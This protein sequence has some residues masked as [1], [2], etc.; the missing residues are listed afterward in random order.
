MTT[1]ELR[2]EIVDGVG[3]ITLNRPHRHNAVTDDLHDDL[4]R[5]TEAYIADAAVRCI[6]LRGEGPSFCSGR[7]TAELGR[8]ATDEDDFSFVLGHQRARLDVLEARKPVVAAI[9]GVALGGGFEIALAADIR[10]IADDAVFGLPEIELGLVPD[11]GGTQILPTLIGPARAKYLIFSGARIDAATAY[12]W[13]LAEEVVPVDRL[14]DRA[15]EFSRHLAAQPVLAMSMAKMLV[16]QATAP[17]IRAGIG[18]ELLAQT[19]LFASAEV[20]RI[21]A[22]AKRNGQTRVPNT[23]GL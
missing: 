6:L 11:T 20:D 9:Q 15:L 22:R 23:G 17:A 21:N 2:T 13:G 4:C 19:A 10:L 18:A 12:D 8:R 3:I 5:A 16:N 7:D 14:Y 1:A